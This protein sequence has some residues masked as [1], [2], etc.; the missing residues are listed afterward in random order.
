MTLMGSEYRRRHMLRHRRWGGQVASRTEE[1]AGSFGYLG[2]I[3]T[4]PIVPLGVYLSRRRTS[5]FVRWHAAQALNVTLTFTLYL[6]C[7]AIVGFLLSLDTP[8]AALALMIPIAVI[9]WLFTAWQLVRG[10]AAASAG[11]FREMPTWICSPFIR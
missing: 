3:V 9:G 2:G 8:K 5:P 7:G 6:V 10:A 1:L 4:G 11:D